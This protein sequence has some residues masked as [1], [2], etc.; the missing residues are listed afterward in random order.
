LLTWGSKLVETRGETP[1][2]YP[3]EDIMGMDV[4][5]KNK[6]SEV[7]S[8]FRR[9]V[10]GWRPLWKYVELIH[11]DLAEKVE[12][13]Q[14]N[15]GDGLDGKDSSELAR[16]LR[17]DLADGT[18]YRYVSVRNEWLAGLERTACPHCEGTGIRADLVGTDAGMPIRELSP[19]VQVVTGRTH[20]YCNGCSGYGDQ[21]NW[22]T[23]YPLSVTDIEEFADFLE[24]CNGFEIW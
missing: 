13:S 12:H 2:N 22:E 3:E 23:N 24:V 15:D 5:G 4:I 7:G 8:Y 9:N 1:L 19:E 17:A 21:P 16:R 18:A 20:G 10:W 14:S 11:S 6:N